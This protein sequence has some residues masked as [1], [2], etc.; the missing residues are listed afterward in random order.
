MADGKGRRD[1]RGITVR[2][3]ILK[4]FFSI[5]LTNIPLTWILPVK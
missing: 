2:G 4:R 5:P 1:V 3:I